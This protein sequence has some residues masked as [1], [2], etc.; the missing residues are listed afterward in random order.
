MFHHVNY[1]PV[2]RTKVRTRWTPSRRKPGN[3]SSLTMTIKM[4][5]GLVLIQKL[6][7]SG[8][9]QSRPTSRASSPKV[10]SQS[11]RKKKTHEKIQSRILRKSQRNLRKFSDQKRSYYAMLSSSMDDI[12]SSLRQLRRQQPQERGHVHR[13]HC[14]P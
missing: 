5:K 9:P 10:P 11:Q 4:S 13:T 12:K 1:C 8:G 7:F 3:T 2:T 14:L 6:L